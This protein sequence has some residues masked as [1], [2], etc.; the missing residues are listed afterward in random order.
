MNERMK[1]STNR[2][3]Q[4]ENFEQNLRNSNPVDNFSW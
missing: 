4:R 3:V 1:K 2:K